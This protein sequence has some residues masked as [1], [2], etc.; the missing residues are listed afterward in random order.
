VGAVRQC[1]YFFPS[2]LLHAQPQHMGSALLHTLSAALPMS[3][4]ARYIVLEIFPRR[5]RVVML[6]MCVLVS[7]LYYA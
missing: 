1:A 7:Y 3:P 2:K 6:F 4:P 5:N